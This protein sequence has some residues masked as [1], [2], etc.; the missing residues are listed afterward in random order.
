MINVVHVSPIN[1]LLDHDTVGDCACLPVCKPV[2]RDD[3][4]IGY[5]VVHNAWDGRQ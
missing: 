3:G 2:E 4:S 5:V 1:D